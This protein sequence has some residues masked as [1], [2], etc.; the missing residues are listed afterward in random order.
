VSALST[1]ELE[2]LRDVDQFDRLLEQM[3]VRV[4]VGVISQGE[5]EELRGLE[6]YAEVRPLLEEGTDLLMGRMMVSF[7][8]IRSALTP[9]R[10]G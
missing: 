10:Q 8:Q 6:V 3:A 7:D 2:E 5:R 9:P 4:T 1:G